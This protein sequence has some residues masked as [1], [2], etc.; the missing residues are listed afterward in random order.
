[1][2]DALDGRF[3]AGLSGVAH[4]RLPGLTDEDTVALLARLGIRGRESAMT[5]FL[6]HLGNHPLLVG[7]VAGLVRDYRPDPGDFDR[8]IAD[9]AAGGALDVPDLNLTQ[10][11]THILAAALG[12]LSPESRQL[13][14]WIS[15][16]AGAVEWRALD[17]INPFRPEPPGPVKPQLSSLGPQPSSTRLTTGDSTSGL[18]REP[19]DA[20]LTNDTPE[21][22]WFAARERL[23]AEAERAS[24][25]AQ[26]AWP[27]SEPV[28]RAGARLD[29]AL[30]DLD[31]RGLLWWDRSSNSYDLH[32]IVRAYV[33][34]QLDASDRVR[35]NERVRDHFQALPPEPEATAKSVEDLGRTI[36][37][38]RALVGAGQ[39][40]AARALW[41]S[42]LSSVLIEQLGAHV[43]VIEL[44]SPFADDHDTRVLADLSEA[45]YRINRYDEAVESATRRLALALR[46]NSRGETRVALQGLGLTLRASGTIGGFARCVQL[47]EELSKAARSSPSAWL[48]ADLATIARLRGDA[49]QAAFLLDDAQRTADADKN[50]SL[51]TQIRVTRLLV[52]HQLG[53]SV[54]D[55]K[56]SVAEAELG[57]WSGRHALAW[58]RVEYAISRCLLEDALTAANDLERLERDAGMETTPAVSAA[59]L[60]MLH[61]DTE[62]TA[63]VDEA[64]VRSPRLHPA[65]RPHYWLAEAL[66]SLGR[67]DEAALHARSAYRQ[68][69]S[70]GPPNSDCWSLRRANALLELMR[71]PLPMV[72]TTDPATIEV[73]LED[74]VR[75]LIV[76]V[77]AE[78]EA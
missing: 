41:A 38:F 6:G 7:V 50:A 55:G 39:R 76:Q 36:T 75:T 71:V 14:G 60:A 10:R 64:L 57:E 37:I 43:A 2:P 27:A 44:L 53:V 34:E 5:A 18:N 62:A 46:S 22:R 52:Q 42:R 13:L 47:R 54:L 32:P 59:V 16:F 58:L 33:H 74:E 9:P 56:I 31:D 17:A 11:R 3:G 45:Y 23:V 30:H 65:A 25:E 67:S 20:W 19:S 12:E 21:H 48:L 77:A 35:A 51:L 63:A 49:R 1:M 66:R 68:A 70:D 24:L 73:P 78:R 61:R 40:N 72:C 69:W 26:A 4:L 29:A 28:I 8:W 15:V